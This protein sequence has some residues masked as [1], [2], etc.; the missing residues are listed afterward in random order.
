[1]DARVAA[2]R[3]NGYTPQFDIATYFLH[4]VPEEVL[5]RRPSRQRE[6]SDPVFGQPCHFEQWPEIPMRVIAAADDRL[7]Q[8]EFQKRIARERLNAEVEVIPGGHLVALSR[9]EELAVRL[10]RFGREVFR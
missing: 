8:L 1:M 2:A 6:Q 9:P 5:R 10:L 7:F 4:D 3:A